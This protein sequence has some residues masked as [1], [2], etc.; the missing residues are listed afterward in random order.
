MARFD[1]T[2]Y[3]DRLAFEA[4][5]GRI[6]R[7]EIDQAFHATAAWLRGQRL[8]LAGQLRRFAESRGHNLQRRL[9]H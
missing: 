5:A 1:P 7:E 9:T 4:H 8:E 2:G 6:R 3:P